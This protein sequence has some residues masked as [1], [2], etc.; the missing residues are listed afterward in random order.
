MPE[1][2]LPPHR[3]DVAT[4]GPRSRS[5]YDGPVTSPANDPGERPPRLDRPPSDRYRPAL[6]D[7]ARDPERQRLDAITV[8]LGLILA[9]AIVFVV[10]GGILTVTAGLVIVG[11]LAGWLT[12]RLVSP[13]GRAA[14]VG[15]AAVAIGFLGVWLYG[16]IEGG[17]LDP[18]AYLF[19]VEGPAVVVLSL[20]AGGG[21]AAAASR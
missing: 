20:L 18:I 17:V 4:R 2:P 1:L 8:P 11:A 19:E 5:R 14:V 13:P 16:R 3:P 7:P 12:G 15:L 10:L 6:C 9:T 21:L